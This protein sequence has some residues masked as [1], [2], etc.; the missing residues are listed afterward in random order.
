MTDDHSHA[1]PSPDLPDPIDN[2]LPDTE[3]PALSHQSRGEDAA[4]RARSRATSYVTAPPPPVAEDDPLLDFAPV[5]HTA[6]R[7]N[8]ITP[9]RQRRFIAHLAAT[10]IVKQ[11]AKHIGASLEAL[12]KLRQRPGAAEFCRA[13]DMAVDRG[14]S[15]LEDCALARAIEGE[16]RMVVSAGKVLGTERRHNEALVMFFLRQRRADRYGPDI[17]PGHPL[18]ERIRAEVLEEQRANRPSKEEVLARL[19]AKID[20]MRERRAAAERLLAEDEQTRS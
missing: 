8:S 12:Y 5:P 16:E 1:T 9:D 17:G 10:G 4:V 20:R 13:W 11:A 6:P 7:R 3:P 2:H 19:N 15:R 18:Y 14:V